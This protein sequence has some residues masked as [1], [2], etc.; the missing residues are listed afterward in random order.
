MGS[1]PTQ[2][3]RDEEAVVSVNDT[4]I[5]DDSRKLNFIEGS[6]ITINAVEDIPNNEMDITF[7]STGGGGDGN[8]W[9]TRRRSW[10]GL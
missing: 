6:N 3:R 7:S 1:N 9:I 10:M 8:D 5:S 4:P 2:G